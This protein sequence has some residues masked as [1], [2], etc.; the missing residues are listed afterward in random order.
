MDRVAPPGHSGNGQSGR[1]NPSS[2]PQ[3]FSAYHAGTEKRFS[4]SS[5]SSSSVE[6]RASNVRWTGP[7][8][9]LPA[10]TIKAERCHVFPAFNPGLSAPPVRQSASNEGY[11]GFHP[12]SAQHRSSVSGITE[13]VAP[14]KKPIAMV[15]PASF[16]T[17][18]VRVAFRNSLARSGITNTGSSLKPSSSFG[19]KIQIGPYIASWQR[20]QPFTL[21]VGRMRDG[22]LVTRTTGREACSSRARRA[23][24]NTLSTAAGMVPCP[25]APTCGACAPAGALC[26]WSLAGCVLSDIESTAFFNAIREVMGYLV[27]TRGGAYYLVLVPLPDENTG[28][29]HSA[30]EQKLDALEQARFVWKRIDWNKA[31][32]EFDDLT[33]TDLAIE[34]EWPADVS[35]AAIMSRTF[36]ERN[37]LQDTN[38]PILKLFR[39]NA[40][41]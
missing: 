7:S 40:D 11:D 6:C 9:L 32:R 33:A 30:V 5:S 13:S 20:N 41:S 31:Q 27:Y 10:R 23:F 14:K 16:T 29:L 1:P 28:R 17:H 2:K 35:E 39:Q 19:R 15:R 34:P 21:V 4:S 3:S 36:G 8:R 22:F 25:F 26:C 38:D 12:A 24:S 37:V 18:E